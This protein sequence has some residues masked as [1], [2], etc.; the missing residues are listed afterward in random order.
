MIEMTIIATEEVTVIVTV[1]EEIIMI[2]TVTEEM[3]AAGKEVVPAAV[4][5]NLFSLDH[6]AVSR[7]RGLAAARA[8]KNKCT[9]KRQSF[10]VS[11][12]C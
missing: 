6:L 7:I 2:V 5:M 8:R 11:L 10:G 3:T 4:R 1:T 12:L 9:G